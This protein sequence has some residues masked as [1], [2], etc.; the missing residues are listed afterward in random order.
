VRKKHRIESQIIIVFKNPIDIGSLTWGEGVYHRGIAENGLSSGVT[1]NTSRYIALSNPSASRHWVQSSLVYNPQSA[2][3]SID[4]VFSAIHESVPETYHTTYIPRS[5]C[6]S[7]SFL[8]NT[9][10]PLHLL[11]HLFN[12]PLSIVRFFIFD[13]GVCW[14]FQ[15][16]QSSP[17]ISSVTREGIDKLTCEP[18]ISRVSQEQH[19]SRS[20]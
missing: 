15:F 2:S 6:R 7:G 8:L 10:H 16:L 19:L 12:S 3:Q 4:P 11:D 17:Y 13:T 1:Y 20:I 14:F 9:L 5:S 18:L